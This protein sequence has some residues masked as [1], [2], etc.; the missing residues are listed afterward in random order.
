MA[1]IEF[2]VPKGAILFS[3]EGIS[4]EFRDNLG[5]AHHGLN[6]LLARPRRPDGEPLGK[7]LLKAVGMPSGPAWERVDKAR[8]KLSR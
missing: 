5:E 8:A 6:L 3:R 7:V 2:Q 1:A 4:Y